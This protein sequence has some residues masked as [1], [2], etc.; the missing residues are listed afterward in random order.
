MRIS[1]IKNGEG[2]FIEGRLANRNLDRFNAEFVVQIPR[3]LDVVKVETR[4][5][6]LNLSSI[7]ATVLGAT[8]GGG[9]KLW[10]RQSQP[11]GRERRG[12][13]WNDRGEC[14]CGQRQ[15]A[16]A[17][18]Y[19]WRQCRTVQ[20]ESGRAGGNGSRRNYGGVCGQAR[21]LR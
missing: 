3:Q 14:T 8:G 2:S 6:S 11:G 20:S 16:G 19:G 4:G 7:A 13:G 9:G 5:G 1:A 12:P 15:G 10:R 17:G 21:R 18:Q